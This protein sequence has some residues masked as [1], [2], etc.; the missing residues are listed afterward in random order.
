MKKDK[1]GIIYVCGDEDVERY[2]QKMHGYAYWSAGFDEVLKKNGL[3]DLLKLP[4]SVLEDAAL[5]DTAQILFLAWIPE[6]F[7]NESMIANLLKYK[8]V[9]IAEGFV[10]KALHGRFG[11]QGGKSASAR[12]LYA[13]VQDSA[14]LDFL[15]KNLGG[16]LTNGLIN[17]STKE[18][19]TREILLN[20]WDIDFDPEKID[21]HDLLNRIIRSFKIPY[22]NRV[23]NKSLMPSTRDSLLML[24]FVGRYG[25]LSGQVFNE[26]DN[27][28]IS[29]FFSLLPT[30]GG[31]LEFQVRQIFEGVSF[32]EGEEEKKK[33]YLEPALRSTA[34]KMREVLNGKSSLL[35]DDEKDMC[36]LTALQPLTESEKSE[37]LSFIGRRI[38][39]RD[40]KPEFLKPSNL[41]E[42]AKI[43]LALVQ[44][45]RKQEA[46]SVFD[47]LVK[48]A[49]DMNEGRFN[50]IVLHE[51]KV[52]L[53]EG[54][55]THPL[56]AYA[57][58]LL[59]DKVQEEVFIGHSF[60][61]KYGRRRMDMWTS[62][63]YEICGYNSDT[64]RVVASFSGGD[65]A[66]LTEHRGAVLFGFQAFSYLV[67]YHTMHPLRGPFTDCDASGAI[68]IEAVMLYVLE[69]AACKLG[70]S[71]V[72][73]AAW[74]S[75]YDICLTIRHDVDRIPDEKTFSDLLEF[76][77]QN[78]LGVSWY[79]IFSRLN[80][81]YIHQMEDAGHEI[82]LHAMRHNT[83]AKI[84]E[85]KVLSSCLKKQD[86]I[87][88]EFVH[89]GGGGEYWLGWPS[90]DA[91]EK[92]GLSYCE[93]V[94]TLYGFPYF[95][96]YVDEQGLVKISP[97]VALSH[98]VSVDR[99]NDT[100]ERPWNKARIDNIISCGYHLMILNHPDQYLERLKLIVSDVPSQRRLDWTAQQV[101][102]WWKKT[103]GGNLVLLS[104]ATDAG[105]HCKVVAPVDI[106]GLQIL[107]FDPSVNAYVPWALSL[108][109]NIAQEV[110]VE[111]KNQSTAAANH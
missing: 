83:S 3:I 17:V 5:L 106:E 26:Q 111:F 24:S 51:K 27:K 36:L 22:W 95:F 66:M 86:S 49:F 82:G 91:A 70:K 65:G 16:F 72:R 1:H 75:G 99:H 42:A 28:L 20:R 6:Y 63:P 67:H 44:M 79:W 89:G 93:K 105:V 54:V 110:F 88:G 97:I 15:K 45:N 61:E 33:R 73:V 12:S 50:N 38:V 8:G 109:P 64:A 34:L 77:R 78:A 92:A 41:T 47:I 7:W 94:S 69:E 103:H 39:F 40:G 80:T 32:A 81:D 14:L 13:Q 55:C 60:D 19:E 102:E 68:L 96:P 84:G 31:A 104:Q 37:L 4:Q 71:F 101:A 2:V 59:A 108:V 76:E 62:S 58:L 21:R 107:V 30:E 25:L 35:R 74:P 10:P 98:S 29:E 53:T 85:I 46:W 48:N 90:V 57:M 11:I 18:I 56:L 52:R 87:V 9:I 23:K 100:S 43:I